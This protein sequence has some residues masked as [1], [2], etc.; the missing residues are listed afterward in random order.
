L[1][2][3]KNIAPFFSVSDSEQVFSRRAGVSRQRRRRLGR[4][5]GEKV[6]VV[7]SELSAVPGWMKSVAGSGVDVIITIFCDFC[8]FSAKK[9]AIFSK[10]NVMIKFLQKNSSSL[11][12]KRHFLPKNS[13]KIFKKS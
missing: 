5:S 11:S 6:P 2:W 13:A 1:T 3:T 7:G 8:K 12:K 10:T 4:P 9:L